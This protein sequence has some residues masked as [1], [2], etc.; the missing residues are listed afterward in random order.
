M[1]VPTMAFV[2]PGQNSHFVGM[3][4]DLHE[5][6]GASRAILEAA[7]EV[8]G[9]PLTELMFEGPED[10]LTATQNQ[11]PAILTHSAVCLAQ[12][13][14]RGLQPRMVAGHSLGEYSALIAA[15][16]LGFE[17]ALR[18]VRKRGALMAAAGGGAMAAVI[19]LDAPAIEAACRRAQEVG[20]VGIANYNCPGQVV[21]T[22]QPEA[23][24]EASRL[25]QEAGAKRVVPLRVSGAFHS[26]LMQAAADG[27]RPV[28]DA[29]PFAD[30]RVPLVS[31]VDAE[32]RTDG[33]QIRD[34]LARQITGAVL[35]EASVRRMA[36]EGIDTFV[37]VGPGKVL[38]GLVRRTCPD[39]I[40]H[41]AG[42]ADDLA[43]LAV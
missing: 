41:A 10:E 18:V 33:R 17:E 14:E 5:A 22:G 32:P 1:L 15:G 31:N 34:A 40:V 4:R 25:I 9:F 2:F 12:L 16:C 7:D 42:T 13:A 8:L 36:A 20:V 43:S 19:G 30:A 37:E 21:I 38:A 27:L 35:W 28:L 29:A 26:A 3:A 23:V 24:R 6:G 39:V 11:Q